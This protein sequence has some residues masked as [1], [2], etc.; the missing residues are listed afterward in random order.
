MDGVRGHVQ[1]VADSVGV[2]LSL[3]CDSHLAFQDK[4]R[5]HGGVSVV[6][7]EDTRAVFPDVGVREAFRAQVLF[8]VS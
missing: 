5:G 8:K 6:R 3:Q 1:A 4:V 2:G 7:I